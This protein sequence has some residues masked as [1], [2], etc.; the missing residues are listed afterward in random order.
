MTNHSGRGT[1]FL[2]S[3]PGFS[4]PVAQVPPLVAAGITL[5]HADQT[6]A[7][8]QQQ[9]LLIARQLEPDAATNAKKVGAQYILLNYIPPGTPGAHTSI[10]NTPAWLILYQSIPSAPNDTSADPT[11]SSNS[12]HDL[13]VFLDANSGKELLKVWV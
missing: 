8:N 9:A 1:S 6:S 5:G 4:P 13:Y 12:S 11:S 3:L 2:F 10:S 7:L